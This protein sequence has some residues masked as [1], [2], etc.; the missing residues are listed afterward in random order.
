MFIYIKNTYLKI[1]QF[2]YNQFK[3]IKFIEE[4]TKDELIEKN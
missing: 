3:M 1:S 4:Y 2:I